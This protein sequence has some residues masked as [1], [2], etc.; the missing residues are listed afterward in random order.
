MRVEALDRRCAW[1]LV[2]Q[3]SVGSVLEDDDVV[4]VDEELGGE[5]EALLAAL[6]DEHAVGRTRHPVSG[7]P[8][9]DQSSQ[10]GQPVREGVLQ[11]RRVLRCQQLVVDRVELVDGEEGRVGVAAGEGCDARVAGEGE[12]LPDR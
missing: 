6:G 9:R 5:V 12:E 4:G 2:P 7:Q 8:R 11:G 3:L 10:L 1:A